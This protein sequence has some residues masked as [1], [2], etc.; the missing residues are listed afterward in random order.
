MHYV[1]V[2]ESLDGKARYVGCSSDLKKRFTSH[3]AGENPATRGKQWQIIYYEAYQTLQLARKRE[4]K[5]KN[6]GR[7][8]RYLF[9]R[10]FGAG[11]SDL[12]AR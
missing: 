7:V 11:E 5:L 3:N 10:L 2:L 12:L 4:Y 9:E 6:D 8:K 1:Y